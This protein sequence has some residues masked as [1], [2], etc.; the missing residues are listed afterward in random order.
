MRR[1]SEVRAAPSTGTIRT[2]V[3][4]EPAAEQVFAALARLLWPT[5]TAAHLG[6]AAGCSERAAEFYLAGDRDWSGDAV[7]A[8]V[9]EV[10][11]RHSMR[12]VRVTKR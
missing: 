9:S 12:N 1:L 11:K 4:S 2:S 5:K 7:T 6:A 10:L 3:E 8:I